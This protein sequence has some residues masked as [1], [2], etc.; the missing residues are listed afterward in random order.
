MKFKIFFVFIFLIILSCKSIEHI[1]TETEIINDLKFYLNNKV[2]EEAILNDENNYL[3]KPI[4]YKNF[5]YIIYFILE[6]EI[7]KTAGIKYI[8]DDYDLLIIE[9]NKFEKIFNDLTENS[10][11]DIDRMLNEDNL[12]IKWEYQNNKY[13]I[14]LPEINYD[15]LEYSFFIEIE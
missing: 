4:F 1:K 5:K 12:T 13:W 8:F 11:P 15:T 10:E 2:P 6:N 9:Q 7:I 14:S 3:L